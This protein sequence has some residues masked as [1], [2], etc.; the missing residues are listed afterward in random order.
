M[1]GGWLSLTRA[2]YRIVHASAWYGN[3]LVMHEHTLV[4]SQ[5]MA[6]GVHSKANGWEESESWQRGRDGQVFCERACHH[7][8]RIMACS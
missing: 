5:D 6:T 2:V 8:R 3:A 4:R 1:S 7:D